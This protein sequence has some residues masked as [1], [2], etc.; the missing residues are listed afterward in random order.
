MADKSATQAFPLGIIIG[1]AVGIAIGITLKSIAIGIGA[2][3]GLAV[4]FGLMLDR[5]RRDSS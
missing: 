1:V 2:G 3:S 4:L 5:R